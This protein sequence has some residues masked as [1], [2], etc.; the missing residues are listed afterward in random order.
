MLF[1]ALLTLRATLELQRARVEALYLA[2]D[3]A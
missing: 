3:E 2:E 1:T